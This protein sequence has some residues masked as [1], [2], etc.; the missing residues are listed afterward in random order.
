[1]RIDNVSQPFS[2]LPQP[3][4]KGAQ[5]VLP[6]LQEPSIDS[7]I[8]DSVPPVFGDPDVP[9]QIGAAHQNSH[10]DPIK[11]LDVPGEP[12][13]PQIASKGLSK[14][15]PSSGTIAAMSFNARNNGGES[16]QFEPPLKRDLPVP[17]QI[18]GQTPEP[19]ASKL[20]PEK[21]TETVLA[22][23]V[24]EKT[25][26]RQTNNSD[27]PTRERIAIRPTDTAAL[28]SVPVAVLGKREEGTQSASL[29]TGQGEH[30][31]PDQDVNTVP[32]TSK[33][34]EKPDPSSTTIEKAVTAPS[35][36]PPL[37]EVKS[38][39]SA[40]GE[41]FDAPTEE[42]ALQNGREV[43]TQTNAQSQS[44]IVTAQNT[45]RNIA[46]QLLATITSHDA[47]TS[48]IH[49][50]PKELGSVRMQLVV[51]DSTISLT[52]LAERQETHD[53][54]RRNIETLTEEFR[55]LGYSAINLSFGNDGQSNDP[56]HQDGPVIDARESDGTTDDADTVSQM[57][58]TSGLDLRL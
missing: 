26:G 29:K 41:T 16:P 19:A 9:I 13:P 54:M 49:L 58:Q 20:L 46:Q 18:Q 47:N 17:Q 28:Q 22:K 4:I 2:I 42:I 11:K 10:V 23:P 43:S 55:H 44:V 8:N 27:L 3:Q 25:I 36:L 40:L 37:P 52:I 15:N 48:E 6:K 24:V 38:G 5:Q 32:R 30:S 12:A 7:A 34:F 45:T 31:H 35:V 33:D 57:A 14:S 1:M 50:N 51:Q 39:I 53:L 21:G 56:A